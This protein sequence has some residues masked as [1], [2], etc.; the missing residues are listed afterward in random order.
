MSSDDKTK[1]IHL[2]RPEVQSP[3]GHERLIRTLLTI[4]E[5]SESDQDELRAVPGR[6]R[7]LSTYEDIVSEGDRPNA[8]SVLV[9][10]FAC[11][12]KILH[13]GRRQIVSFHMA[14]DAPD[15]QSLYID[16]MDHSLGTLE[17]STVLHIAHETMHDL[18]RRKPE[19][20]ALFWRW[21]LI[22]ASVFREW[23]V[24]VGQREAYS[25]LAHVLCEVMTRMKAVGLADGKT[26][27]FPLTQSELGDTTGMS[28]VHVNRTLQALRGDGLIRLK[29]GS[30]TVLDW[31]GLTVAG[32]FDPAYLHL[33][34]LVA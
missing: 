12:Y 8:I 28:T 3:S 2:V 30:L 27:Q 4:G 13:D 16:R 19:I 26:C 31:E 11:R 24:N 22:E 14:G 25:R 9:D 1:L 29:A 20:G 23:V 18:F 5:L 34:E 33:R 17:D 7:R 6:I 21:T 15:I 10:G 32:E